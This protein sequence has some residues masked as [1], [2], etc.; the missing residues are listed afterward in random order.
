MSGSLTVNADII[1]KESKFISETQ[2]T[3]STS[4]AAIYAFAHATFSAAEVLITATETTKK[5]ITK[6]LITHNGS[7]AIATEYG[8]VYTNTELAD[9]DVS[10]VG[11]TLQI[12]A[13]PA[14]SISTTFKIVATLIDA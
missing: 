12:L 11:P 6:L 10:I 4:Q 1:Q 9:Y 2:T 14:S 5:H 7:T 3:T 13:T 8:V